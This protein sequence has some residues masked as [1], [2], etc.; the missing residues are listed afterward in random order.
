MTNGVETRRSET[1]HPVFSESISHS[2]SL[3]ITP[4]LARA[5]DLSSSPPSAST[6]CPGSKMN[7][8]FDARSQV[9]APSI[10]EASRAPTSATAI[11]SR[12]SL[13]SGQEPC[14]SA[15]GWKNA[16]CRSFESVPMIAVAVTWSLSTCTRVTSIPRS[17]IRVVYSPPSF[18]TVPTR[19]GS[20]PRSRRFHAMFAPVP[21][22]C[23]VKCGLK[24]ETDSFSISAFFRA[25][26]NEPS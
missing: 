11:S 19:S 16:I 4:A 21:P 8:T 25:S 13:R 15:P 1:A 10:S 2:N 3:V 14:V 7:G 6:C 5:E 24:K 20:W 9:T 26:A 18:P 17:F 12:S 23:R 22:W